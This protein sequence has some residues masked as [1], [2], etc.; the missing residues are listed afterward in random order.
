MKTSNLDLRTYFFL[1]LNF[2]LN[3]LIAY[4]ST[5]FFLIVLIDEGLYGQADE[6]KVK[7]MESWIVKI[8]KM[9]YFPASED[10]M[11]KLSY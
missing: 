2:V 5:I 9:K 1:P 8:E 10:E 11:T 4:L 6:G 7:K 3:I